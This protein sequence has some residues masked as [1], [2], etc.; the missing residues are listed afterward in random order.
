VT[1]KA[2]QHSALKLVNHI[3][4]LVYSRPWVLPFVEHA[5]GRYRERSPLIYVTTPLAHA[6]Q[7]DREL[8]LVPDHPIVAS[9]PDEATD[10]D[11]II[12]ALPRLKREDL[13]TVAR[14]VT[15][16]ATQRLHEE[17]RRQ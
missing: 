1:L 16:L 13:A 7:V 17:R 5:A 6:P 2:A 11:V 15:A 14:V 4:D 3:Q 9:T 8:L 10:M 12:D